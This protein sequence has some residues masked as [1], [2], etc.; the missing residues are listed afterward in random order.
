M[1]KNLTTWII[2]LTLII[3]EIHTLPFFSDAKAENWILRAY[4]P[5]TQTWN[6]IYLEW[7][8]KVP[9][10]FLAF[11]FWKSN[12]IN[13]TTVTAMLFAGLIDTIMYFYDFKK[14]LY[15]GSFYVWLALIWVLVYYW[16]TD[17]GILV[18]TLF[19]QRWKK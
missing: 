10:Y 3:G 9:L 7:Q 4:K 1:R 12:K 6:M 17:K 15:F 8:I 19:H 16:R 14:P 2:L 18:K 11:K 5:M 13:L